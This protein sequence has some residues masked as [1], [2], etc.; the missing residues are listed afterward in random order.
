M[1]SE[2]MLIRIF[3]VV[4][5]FVMPAYGADELFRKAKSKSCFLFSWGKGPNWTADVDMEFHRHH[6][7][8]KRPYVDDQYF[9][10]T[11][12]ALTWIERTVEPSISEIA[13]V[14]GR[15]LLRVDY[16]IKG[17]FGRKIECVMLAIETEPKSDWFTPFF[18]A[19]P[20]LFSGRFV[21]SDSTR[22]GYIASLEFSGT[23]A[24]RT[25]HLFDLTGV[26]P[27]LVGSASAGRV[28]SVDYDTDEAYRKALKTFE[29]ES[30]LL[31]GVIVGQPAADSKPK[32]KVK[33]Q[34]GSE[35]PSQ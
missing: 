4:A 8:L 32:G 15:K 9:E 6:L 7:N 25:H 27:T 2:K 11:P 14:D 24:V 19:Q 13:R 26:H 5:A 30:K 28:R 23:G 20:E 18:V 22:I 35:E 31:N 12:K 1:F 33:S 21:S 17:K 34:P 10:P 3:I 16:P 29:T